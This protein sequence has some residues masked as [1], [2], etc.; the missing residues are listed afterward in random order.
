MSFHKP[1]SKWE[2]NKVDWNDPELQALLQR[3]ESWTLDNRGSFSRQDVEL[4]VGWGAGSGRPAVLVWE[5]GQALVVETQFPLA[6]DEPVR[7]D[8]HTPAG[9]R[10]VWGVVADGRKGTRSEDE[11]QGIYVHW[12]HL[13]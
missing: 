6:K 4:H 8:R 2:S 13:R 3:S 11:A 7:V 12:V 1:P 10:S 9:L 5:R